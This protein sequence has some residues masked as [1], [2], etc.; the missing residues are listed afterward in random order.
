[1]L[2]IPAGPNG[3]SRSSLPLGAEFPLAASSRTPPMK[4]E[5]CPAVCCLG[6]AGANLPRGPLLEVVASAPPDLPGTG[7]APLDEQASVTAGMAVL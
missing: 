2:P 3:S 4:L 6:T 7:L 5:V 1:M